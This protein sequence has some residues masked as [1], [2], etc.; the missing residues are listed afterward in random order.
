MP[1][2]GALRY[3]LGIRR[4]PSVYLHVGSAV[5]ESVTQD[6]QSKIDTGELL[7]RQD[8][9]DIAATTFETKEA[10]DPFEI[11]L[12]EKKDG[13]TKEQAKA[14]ALDKSVALA[15]LHYDKAAP[16]INP[17]HVQ[18]RFSINMDA[19]FR[20]RGK[21]LH[22]DAEAEQDS[23]ASKVLH[24]EAR[25]MNSAARIGTD[26]AGA[27]DVVE[28]QSDGLVIRDTKTSKRTPSETSAEDSTQLVSYGMA[29]LVLDKQLPKSTVLDYLVRT[30]KRHDLSYVPRSSTVSM[31]DINVFLFRFARAVHSWNTACKTGSFLP[32]NE[33]AWQCSEAWCGYWGICPAAR[34][35]KTVAVPQLVQIKTK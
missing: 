10:R 28:E 24:A 22:N 15:G 33:D 19:W 6:L 13:V 4:P 1:T 5:D 20:N 14:E 30:Q 34:R 35:P 32:A 11:D 8:A 18:R 23:S 7:K 2:S 27:I 29:T 21:Q 3:N 26:F 12:S 31:D 16:V 9:I 17:K 25:A